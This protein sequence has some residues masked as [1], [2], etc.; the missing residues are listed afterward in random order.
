MSPASNTD[1]VVVGA[2]FAGLA[3][4]HALASAGIRTMV[5]EKKANSG[6]KFHTT[7]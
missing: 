5:L 6:E 3:W 4:A 7:G 2:N 1:C